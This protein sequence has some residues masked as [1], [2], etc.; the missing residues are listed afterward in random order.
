[1]TRRVSIAALQRQLDALEPPIRRAFAD[2]I[3]QLLRDVQPGAVERLIREGRVDEI[4]QVLGMDAAALSTLTESVRAAYVAAGAA[5][6]GELPVFRRDGVAIRVRFNVANPRADAWLRQSSSE[7][8]AAIVSEQR[9][10][11]RTIVAEGTRLGRNPRTT[12]LDI[13]G[14]VGQTGRRAGGVVGLT[15][16]QAQFVANARAQLLSGDPEAMRRYLERK[17]RDRR[18]DGIV[19]R[20]IAAERPVAASDVDRITGR[21][22]DRLLK[23]R[24]ENIAR[25]EALT[26]FNTA[27]DEAYAQAIDTGAVRPEN[28]TKGWSTAGDGRVR[29]THAAMNGRRVPFREPFVLPSGARM[30]YPLDRSLGAPAAEIVNCRCLSVNRIDFLAEN[31]G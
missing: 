27:R 31:L 16:Q 18:F 13:V 7:L 8:V 4:L 28:V 17:A 9:E 10:A 22:A 25:T 2:A 20:A 26:A 23:L 15:S 30:M 11:I 6:V 14:R 12:A 24:G 19:R 3:A 5:A 21:Y 1:M 29:D